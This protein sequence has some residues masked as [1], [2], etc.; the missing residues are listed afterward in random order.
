MHDPMSV[1]H[2]IYLGSKKKKNGQYR[3]PFITIWH[4]DP[5]KDGTD[6]SCGSFIRQRHIPPDLIEK[7]R[8]EFQFQFKHNYWFNEAG[9]P[10]FS[11]MGVC[12]QMYSQTAWKVFMWLDGNNPSR[13]ARRRYKKFMHKHLFDILHF[14][15]NPTDSLYDGINM[16]YGVE[17]KEE[18]INH[19]VSVVLSDIMRKLRPWYKHP[20]W[21]IHH[22]RIQ[23]H[24][25]QKL[26]RRYWDKCCICGK[27]GFKESAIGDWDCTKIWHQEC[28]KSMAKPQR[29]ME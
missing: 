16:T 15:E 25:W 5:E 21:H 17:K 3:S 2:D 23:F 6:D 12:L 10:K 14:A 22:W 24:P 27:R 29:I 7:V 19:F 11:T 8:K 20:R 4:V 13:K 28:D 18:R 26:K 9:Y 1:A